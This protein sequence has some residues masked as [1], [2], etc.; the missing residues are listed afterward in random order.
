MSRSIPRSWVLAPALVAAC[1]TVAA[2]GAH[3]D[4]AIIVRYPDG[5]VWVQLQGDYAGT[6]YTVLRSDG[7]AA[8]W[9]PVTTHDALCIGDCFVR[10]AGIVP[11]RTYYYRFDLI[12]SDGS[13]VS[14]GPYAV[15]IPARPFQ[16]RLTPNPG[17]G[18]TQVM[19]SVPGG[20]DEPP[21]DAEARILD[22]QGRSVRLLY[23][24]PLARGVTTIAWDGRGDG[25]Q[26]LRSGIYYLRFS[27]PLGL[28]V[29]RIVRIR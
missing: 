27:S 2:L 13:E 7:S 5:A 24:G 21:V 26:V 3:A 4:P 16:A 10:D 19:L 28:A 17:S 14:Y 25:G 22:L 8:E 29:A 1:A 6:H 11:G 12:R 23:R 18:V 9:T 15:A 20:R